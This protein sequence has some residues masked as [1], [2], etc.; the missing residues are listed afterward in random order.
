M[1]KTSIKSVALFFVLGFIFGMAVT[2]V[3]K[4][5]FDN[6][7][8]RVFYDEGVVNDVGRFDEIDNVALSDE[9]AG[10][11]IYL[12]ADNENSSEKN[13]GDKNMQS[14]GN[15]KLNDG[16][17]SVT[18]Q[19][20]GLTVIVER[21]DM[22]D[23]DSG[24]WV[25]VH[26][27]K[28]DRIANALGASRRDAGEYENVEVKLLRGTV[29]GGEYAVILYNDNGDRKFDLNKDFPVRTENGEYIMSTFSAK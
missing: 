3:W 18:D 20:A 14:E 11:D 2:G 8:N 28:N 13:G 16:K 25:V 22:R 12:S 24:G 27:I 21:V 7:D 10:E 5:V 9:D 19:S 29:S 23:F 15:A 17:I 6:G 1:N 4:S 26:E